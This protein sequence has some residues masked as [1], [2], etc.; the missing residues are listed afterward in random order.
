M[1][2]AARTRPPVVQVN[3]TIGKHQLMEA[4]CEATI[5]NE[6]F[7]RDV[8]WWSVQDAIDLE[9]AAALIRL[10]IKVKEDQRG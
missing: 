8:G 10:E 3:A 5:R 2:G 6:D 4:L 7:D 1:G 9:M